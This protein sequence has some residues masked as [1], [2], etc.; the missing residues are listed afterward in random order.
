MD[1][2]NVLRRSAVTYL[3]A[4]SVLL[5]SV[6]GELPDDWQQYAAR[7]VVFLGSAVAIIRRVSPVPPSERGLLP[8]EPREDGGGDDE[9]L[10]W[11]PDR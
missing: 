3:T 5:V 1:R 11:H 9:P 2:L 6:S 7:A 8:S 4:L 10:S